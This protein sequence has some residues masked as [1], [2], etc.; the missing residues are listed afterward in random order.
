MYGA[1][2]VPENIELGIMLC[3]GEVQYS[4]YGRMG[5]EGGREDQSTC[6]LLIHWF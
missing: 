2:T 6:V 1:Y 5:R 4:A 3:L